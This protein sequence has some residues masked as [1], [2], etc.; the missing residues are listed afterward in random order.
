MQHGRPILSLII[1]S[2]ARPLC[3]TNKSHTL[4]H[5]P[6]DSRTRPSLAIS[7]VQLQYSSNASNRP[8]RTESGF[9]MAGGGWALE[10]ATH[11]CDI[12]I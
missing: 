8:T 2:T 12:S 9:A 4:D 5:A 1:T 10:L 3:P 7:Q 6:F 11:S